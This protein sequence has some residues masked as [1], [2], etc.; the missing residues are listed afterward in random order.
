MSET[1]ENVYNATLLQA[2]DKILQSGTENKMYIFSMLTRLRQICC[3]PKLYVDDYEGDSAKLSLTKNIIHDAINSNHR[4]LI[5]SQFTSMLD[6]LDA[7]LTEKGILHYK[8]TGST[9]SEERFRLVDEFNKNTDIKVFLISLKAGG[10]G[11]NL[12]GAD[13]VIHYDP[14]WNFSAESQ[15]SDRVHR[16]GQ[17]HNV[18]IIK[19]IT[20]DSIEEK[21]LELQSKK[22]ELFNK[23]VTEDGNILNKLTN[24][25]LLSLFNI[26][27]Q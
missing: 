23:V 2:R 27:K 17:K 22:K 4:I 16:I 18:Q 24:E 6:L 12:V 26:E 7:T 9:P 11:L 25:E 21:I 20:K 5:F 13:T 8:L 10:T 1:Q 19:L 3:H 14:W 15:A